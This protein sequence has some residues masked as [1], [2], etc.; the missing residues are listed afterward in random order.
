MFNRSKTAVVLGCGPAGMFATHALVEAGWSV[1]IW[2]KNR[3]SHMYGAQYL[4][5][6]IPG[7]P[8]RNRTIDYRIQG[9]LEGYAHKVYGG[10]LQPDRVSPST[11]TGK[12]LAWDIRAAYDSAWERYSDRVVEFDIDA[13]TLRETLAAVRPRLCISTVPAPLLCL[14]GDVY[15]HQF[16]AQK[17]WAI[18]D[19]PEAGQLVP[20]A[21]PGDTVICNGE[22][23]VGWYRKSNVFDRT[24]VEW[25]EGSRPPIDGVAEVQKPISTNC[26]CM[27]GVYRTGRYGRWQKGVL[28]HE[29]Y[30]EVR[31][32]L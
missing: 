27:P 15:Q 18:G 16:F 22:R 24:T 23:E 17:V 6:P 11:L 4:H 31:E 19:A 5:Q 32:L 21:C 13:A 12:H 3:K 1:A 14:G 2:S 28:S 25:P 9:S 7:L 8:E 29:A 26:D 10:T 30:F 20:F